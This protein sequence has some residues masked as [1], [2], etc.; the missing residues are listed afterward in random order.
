MKERIQ[1]MADHLL[2]VEG[3]FVDDPDDPGGATKYGITLNSLQNANWD[4]DKDGD[5][6][7]NDIRLLTKQ[8]ARGFLLERYYFNPGFDRYERFDNLSEVL[9]DY[10]VHSGP[11]QA[12]N[13]LSD[14]ID[15]FI[16]KEIIRPDQ[17]F[18]N[19]LYEINA[20]NYLEQFINTICLQRIGFMHEICLKRPASIKYFMTQ[21]GDKG[22]WIKRVEHFM[23]RRYKLTHVE[24]GK[25]LME[26]DIK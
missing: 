11:Q 3:G 2:K 6:D 8:D 4:L 7:L 14:L 21:S 24:F 23:N 17:S 18:K 13:A 12:W 16:E 25:L 22:G 19:S 5:V 9:F 20:Q 26:L 1:K 15:I 10:S